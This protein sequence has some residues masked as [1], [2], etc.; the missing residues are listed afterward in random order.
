EA[1][2]AKVK[3]QYQDVPMTADVHHQGTAI[4]VEAAKYVDEIRV[5]PGLF[6]FTRPGSRAEGVDF[7]GRADDSV[8]SLR[9]EM[10]YS[11]EEWQ[12]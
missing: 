12:A 8:E 4:A 9:A 10:A 2:K 3:E 11:P 5:N 1:I 7:R 6:V